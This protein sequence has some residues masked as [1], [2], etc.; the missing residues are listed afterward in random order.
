MAKDIFIFR[1]GD[2]GPPDECKGNKLDY[3]LSPEGLEQ[4]RANVQLLVEAARGRAL[5]LLVSPSLRCVT[6]RE[7]APRNARVRVVP[8]FRDID[9]GWLEG[10]RHAEVEQ[11]FPGLLGQLRTDARNRISLPGAEELIPDFRERVLWAY[12]E[13]LQ[14]DAEVT[15]IVTHGCGK[16]EII[17]SVL[18]GAVRY[19][20]HKH[21]AGSLIRSEDGNQRVLVD[22]KALYDGE[23]P[24]A[25]QYL[26]DTSS[27]SRARPA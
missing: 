18:G 21:G 16:E 11:K 23:A 1:H 20:R 10:M 25:W 3:P 27:P 12:G 9:I 24:L 7:F 8:E 26:I 2:A 4:T 6:A 5:E 17:A 15:G 14:S 19:L 22:S 13:A